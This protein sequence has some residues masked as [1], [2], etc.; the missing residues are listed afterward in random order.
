MAGV[1]LGEFQMTTMGRLN[2]VCAFVV[3]LVFAA[4]GSV[5]ATP[6]AP[7]GYA[8]TLNFG[9]PQPLGNGMVFLGPGP[10]PADLGIRAT[11]NI[12]AAD[13]TNADQLWSGGGLGL[14]LSGA[15]YTVGVWDGAAVRATHQEFG[16]R[17]TV[18]DAVA[19]ADHATHVA[20]TIAA[21]GIDPTARGMANGLLIR[22]RDWTNDMAELAADAAL[23]IASNHSYGNVVGWD[24]RIDWGIGP[25]DTWVGDRS[26]YAI[27][28]AEFGYYD[29]D[30]RTLDQVLYN[31]PRLLNVWAAGNDRNDVFTN[32]HG[33]N[34]YVTYLSAGPGGPG[35]YQVSTADYP[36][37]PGDGNGGTGYDCLALGQPVS[38][39][40][41][42]VGAINDITVDPYTNAHVS[43]SSFSSWGPADDGRVKPDVVGNGISLYSTLSSGDAAYGSMSGTSMAS[44]NVT[45][46]AA[47]LIEHLNNRLGVMPRSATTK[48]LIIHTAFDAGNAGPDYVYGWGVVDAAAAALFAIAATTGPNPNAHIIEATFLGTQ[49][50]TSVYL[51]G[52]EPFKATLVWTDP[53][54]PTQ[55]GLLDDTS[56]VLVNDLDL[57][58]TDALAN[59]Y[60]PWTLDVLNPSSPAVR[61]QLNH[62]DNVEQVLID[63]PSA[64]WYT[65]H[66]GYTG[67]EPFQQDF[68]LLFNGFLR[69]TQEEIPEPATCLLL[70][71]G[72][73]A[74]AR[75]RRRS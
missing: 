25:V 41:L 62:L 48:G 13:T 6:V 33:D 17:V 3:V 24:T 27:E 20:G 16:G 43:M 55:S 26:I 11:T 64:G 75:R 38:K 36:A 73:A 39:N 59:I 74:L 72:C 49:W 5:W 45:G 44:P 30:A 34:T 54:G 57:W 70:L 35:W 68:S 40:N 22:S 69:Q 37:P 46:T 1:F 67:Q 7:E 50:T 42:V 19:A 61:T 29:S 58:V 15:G 65:L 28:P 10:S 32:L 56:S 4:V 23:I 18:I 51:D 53:A 71:A 52:T 8:A 14:S 2:F 12:N 66:V 60:Y 63:N 21:A 31:N 47:L 9:T